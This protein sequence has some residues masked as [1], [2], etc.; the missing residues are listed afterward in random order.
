[1]FQRFFGEIA[2]VTTL[3]VIVT[4]VSC[5]PEV[6]FVIFDIDAEMPDLETAVEKVPFDHESIKRFFTGELALFGVSD[7]T[8]AVHPFQRTNAVTQET[9]HLLLS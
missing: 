5:C 3:I 9:A 2:G 8:I 4:V 7:T 6:V 1:M